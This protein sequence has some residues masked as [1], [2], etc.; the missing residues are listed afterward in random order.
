MMKA[1]LLNKKCLN[2]HCLSAHSC[3]GGSYFLAAHMSH[4]AKIFT[5]VTFQFLRSSTNVTD[6]LPFSNVG[7]A[8]TAES[9]PNHD[10]KCSFILFFTPCLLFGD[11]R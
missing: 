3:S 5:N 7:S 8:G 4:N 6:G 10:A 1:Q 9:L 11:V 2:L